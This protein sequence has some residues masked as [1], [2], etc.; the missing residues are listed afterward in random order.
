MTIEDFDML[1]EHDKVVLIFEASK[2]TEK[3]DEVAKYQ[4]FKIDNFFVET[5]TS[6]HGEFKR[7]ITTYSL[8][9]LPAEYAGEVVSLPVV[10]SDSKNLELTYSHKSHVTKPQSLFRIRI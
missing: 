2:I 1:S 9:N 7:V 3:T 8:K 10:V 6:L 5:K 4:L